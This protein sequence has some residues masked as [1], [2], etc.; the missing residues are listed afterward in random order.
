L[1]CVA[2]RGLTRTY[3]LVVTRFSFPGLPHA[4][5]LAAEP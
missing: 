1:D 3:G 2:V 5:P 4:A